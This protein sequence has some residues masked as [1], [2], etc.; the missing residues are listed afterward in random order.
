MFLKKRIFENVNSKLKYFQKNKKKRVLPILD[1]NRF[2]DGFR[3]FIWLKL[4]R[5]YNNVLF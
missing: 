5:L 1:S 4:K 2:S 3:I